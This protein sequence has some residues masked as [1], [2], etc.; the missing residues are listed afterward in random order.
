[1]SSFFSNFRKI[2]LNRDLLGKLL[3]SFF[4]WLMVVIFVVIIIF[5]VISAIPG[6]EFFG[7]GGILGTV[8]YN[9]ADKKASIWSPLSVTLLVSFGSLLLATPI[10]VKTA[11]FIK[12]RLNKNYQH[13]ATILAQALSGIPSVV[14]GLFAI[15]SLGPFISSII[16]I[17]LV[18]SIL[19][20]IIMLTFMILPTIITLTL[21]TYNNISNELLFNP[22]SLGLTRT[23]SIYSVYKKQARSGIIIA[24]IIALG[25]A[26]GETMALSMLLTSE[27]YSILGLGI[28]DT[29]KSSL[30][31]LGSLIATNMFSETGGEAIR[32]V[33]YVFGIFLFITIMVLNGIILIFTRKNKIT[34]KYLVNLANL[35]V[36]I[37]RFIP[38]HLF[39][40]FSKYTYKQNDINTNEKITVNNFIS[41]RINNNRFINLKSYYYIALEILSAFITFGFLFWISIDIISN[42]FSVIS[43][44]TTTI[45]D[46]TFNTTGQAIVNTLIIIIVSLCI[47]IP[48][49]LLTAIYLNEYSKDK[50]SKKIILFFVD[51]LGSSPSIIFGM[52]GLTVFIEILGFSLAGSIGKSLLAG[53]LTISIVILPTLIRTIQQSLENVPKDVRINS[54]ALGLTKWLTIW[55]VV[56]PHSMKSLISSVVLAISRIIAETAPL[57]LTA[58]LSSSSAIGLLLPGQTLTTRIYAQLSSTN[59]NDFFNISYECALVAFLLILFLIWLGNYIIPNSRK[60]KNDIIIHMLSIQ[61]CFKLYEANKNLENYQSQIINRTLYVTYNQAADINLNKNYHKIFFK[62]KKLYLIKYI[63]AKKL[64]LLKDP[65]FIKSII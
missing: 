43:N 15:Q 25:R 53:A 55:K 52:F 39:I 30:G 10:G 24:V 50:K 4:A 1:M 33:L 34:N 16:G 5:V 26:I 9:L 45:F 19:N 62:N 8:E 3:S 51:S 41:S 54:Y 49:S 56:I 11:T 13:F 27:S 28:A 48:I 46:Y 12:F 2:K 29:L 14:F 44:G 36:K 21:N 57:Y 20:A 31:T 6:F 22:I 61:W 64:E 7:L 17:E 35:I 47:S 37:V 60:I 23:K 18:Y 65:Q 32:G 63:S 38:D 58:G 59:L 42:G 40:L